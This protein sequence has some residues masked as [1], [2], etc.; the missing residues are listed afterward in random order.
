M[1]PVLRQ[2]V[3]LAQRVGRDDLGERDRGPEQQPVRVGV[4]GAHGRQG[5]ARGVGDLDRLHLVGG[6]CGNGEIMK[7]GLWGEGEGESAV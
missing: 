6:H 1:R 4:E 3:R 5:E 7:G 2:A